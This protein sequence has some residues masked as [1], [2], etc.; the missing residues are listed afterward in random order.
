MRVLL[1]FLLLASFAQAAL[2]SCS[3]LYPQGSNTI[4]FASLSPD[5][6]YDQDKLYTNFSAN[7]SN[8]A[9]QIFTNFSGDPNGVGDIH[10]VVFLPSTGPYWDASVSYPTTISYRIAV[11]DPNNPGAPGLGFLVINSV[12]FDSTTA[13]SGISMT[14]TLSYGTYDAN[15][16]DVPLG[17]T[18]LVSNDGTP[19]SVS[20]LSVKY[21]DVSIAISGVT[22]ANQISSI[23]DAYTQASSAVPEPG[24]Y[25]LFGAGLLAL[26]VLRRRKK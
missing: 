21:I 25:A 26:G 15:G 19:S 3:S 16:N 23:S 10:S 1:C 2:V 20:G 8:I 24:T 7:T 14:K 12:E 17:S 18:Q 5:G 13:G 4:P 22:S 6:C 11:Q 9:A